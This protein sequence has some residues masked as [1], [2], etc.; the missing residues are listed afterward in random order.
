M[1]DLTGEYKPDILRDYATTASPQAFARLVERYVNLVYASA[2]RQC[3]GDSHLAEDVTQAVFIILARKAKSIRSEAVLPAWL[4]STTRYAASNALALETRRRRHEQKAA[5]M[6]NEIREE[7]EEADADVVGPSLDEALAKLREKDRSA[8]TMRFLQGMSMREV[9]VAMGISE[10]AAQKRVVRAVEKLRG[11]FARRGVTMQ[12]A[13]IAS[14]LSR[15][16]AQVAPAALAPVIVSHAMSGVAATPAAATIAHAASHSI[17]A[18]KAKLAGLIAAS[19]AAV[20]VTAGVVVSQKQSAVN[21]SMT[22]PMT[23]ATLAAVAP[24]PIWEPAV[25]PVDAQPIGDVVTFRNAMLVPTAA[26]NMQQYKFGPDPAVRRTPASDPAVDVASTIPNANGMAAEGMLA[27][28]TP[29]RGK[30]V[31]V[32]AY[33]KAR[34]VERCAAMQVAVL[35]WRMRILAVDVMG[36]PQVQ[37]TPT[38]WARVSSVVDVPKDAA[39]IQ[40]AVALW[41]PGTVWMDDFQLAVVPST[42]PTTADGKWHAFTPFTGRYLADADAT[43][44]RNG[45]ATVRLGSDDRIIAR[46]SEFGAYLRLVHAPEIDAYIGRRVRVSAYIKSD[47]VVGSAGVIASASQMG[48]AVARSNRRDLQPPVRGTLDWMRYSAELTVPAGAD[49]LEMGVL[50][51]GR[52]KVWIDDLKI[53]PITLPPSATAHR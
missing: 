41:G 11:F 36:T 32:S 51:Q 9:G 6:A 37:G 5:A 19:I 1:S 14:G 42:V 25:G 39:Q 45:H 26:S 23:P 46:R 20:A 38:D 52:G 40:F 7:Q 33:V 28:A 47:D 8:V 27:I 50:L 31:R 13:A 16:A 48:Q 53:E 22:T 15:Q 34:D 24:S 10:E 43:V 17:F 35:D 21:A 44:N 49:T 4:I 12:T 3:R 30:R 2:R 29:Y 18:A